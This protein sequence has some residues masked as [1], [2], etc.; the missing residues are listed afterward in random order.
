MFL[1]VIL[2]ILIPFVAFS[3]PKKELMK[4]QQQVI[5]IADEYEKAYFERDPDGALLR[6]KTGAIVD[7]FTDRS[8][9]AHA[10][11]QRKEDEFLKALNAEFL[12]QQ[13]CQKYSNA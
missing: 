5:K 7:R 3:A 10:A 2:L 8:F 4:E 9:Q 11:W 13:H 6:G 12:A 1:R